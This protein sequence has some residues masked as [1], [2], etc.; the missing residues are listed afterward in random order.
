MDYVYSSANEY[1]AVVPGNIFFMNDYH[2]YYLDEVGN[3][4]SQTPVFPAG[5]TLEGQTTANFNKWVVLQKPGGENVYNLLLSMAPVSIDSYDEV[6][7]CNFVHRVWYFDNDTRFLGEFPDFSGVYE[8]RLRAAIE[9][10]DHI[11]TRQFHGVDVHLYAVSHEPLLREPGDTFVI[12]AGVND[13]YFLRGAT[14]DTRLYSETRRLEENS[15]MLFFVE[16]S[17]TEIRLSFVLEETDYN[18]PNQ[19]AILTDL[20]QDAPYEPVGSN[21]LNPEFIVL[22]P[23]GINYLFLGF[24]EFNGSNFREIHITAV[25]K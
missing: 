14:P 24:Q 21:P 12:K 10:L 8:R 5:P 15:N 2:E 16:P 1:D 25:D 23:V 17:L 19:A 3:G 20:S 11:S 9:K 6:L 22:K 7:K 13:F 18:E 4:Y